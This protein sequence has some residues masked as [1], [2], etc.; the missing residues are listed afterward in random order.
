MLTGCEDLC[1]WWRLWA[2]AFVFKE[3]A[4]VKHEGFSVVELMLMS[5]KLE[6]KMLI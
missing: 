2:S 4:S 5:G 1:G 3:L 6:V